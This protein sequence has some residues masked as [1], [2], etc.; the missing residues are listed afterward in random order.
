MFLF[1]KPDPAPHPP[2]PDPGKCQ[3]CPPMLIQFAA[4]RLLSLRLPQNNRA[5][6]H[7]RYHGISFWKSNSIFTFAFYVQG[8]PEPMLFLK[9]TLRHEGFHR[10]IL[11]LSWVCSLMLSIYD[12]Q[13]FYWKYLI[14]INSSNEFSMNSHENQQ[15]EINQEKSMN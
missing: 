11:T 4:S 1:P 3:A 5:D 9:C 14:Q 13:I 7:S 8:E 2:L 15:S 6:Y 12:Y 10:K